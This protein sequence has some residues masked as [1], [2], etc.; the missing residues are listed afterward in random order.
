MTEHEEYRP[1]G[2]WEWLVLG[3][4]SGLIAGALKG[5]LE[6]I[7]ILWRTSADDLTV[8]PYGVLLYG[9]VAAVAG[10]G[11]GMAGGIL[12]LP[13]RKNRDDRHKIY[14]I[15][16]TAN[17][18]IMVFV[19]ARFRILRDLFHERIKTTE[20]MGIL[21][22]AGLLLACLLL[23]LVFTSLLKLMM[24]RVRLAGVM[25]RPWCS[26]ILYAILL[27][28]TGV[29]GYVPHLIG[30]TE[31][32]PIPSMF[33]QGDDPRPNVLLIMIDTQRAD[34]LSCY[35][36]PKSISPNIDRL[37]SEGILYTNAIAQAS[38]TK[39]SIATVLSSMY[40]SSHQA[41]H[42]KSI[43]PDEVVTLAE[44]L[45]ENGYYTIGLSNNKNISPTFHFEQGFEHYVFLEPDYFFGASEVSSQLAFYH[46]LRI[47]K[48]RFF[49]SGIYVQHFYQDAE[50]VTDKAISW[51][52]D[53]RGVRSFLFVHYMDPHG[54]Y[55]Y[56]PYDGRGYSRIHMANPPPK[57]AD[58]FREVY[59][60]EV[61][62]CDA[63]I[64]RLL[65]WMRENGLYDQTLI[66][67]TGDHGEEF[68]EHG[69][70]WHGKTLYEEQIHIPLIVKLPGT[71]LKGT[72][73]DRPVRHIDVAPTILDWLEL[74][75][76]DAWQG[77]PLLAGNDPEIDH[78][79]FSEE[80]FEGNVVR[81]I[82][83]KDRKLILANEGNPRGLKPME[84]YHL[85]SD[86]EESNNLVGV[87]GT[88]SVVSE[89]KA[90]MEGIE[91]YAVKNSVQ[92]ETKELDA[93]TQ[94]QLKALGYIQ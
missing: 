58:L 41:I 70:W 69:G 75:S 88:E 57:A 71:E 62:F 14:S 34:H 43:L 93:A 33:L 35:G 60:G 8:I 27:F 74:E 11:Y 13:F 73:I 86:P 90:Y 45:Q 83:S 17:F 6:G 63:H 5:I 28:V 20:P 1:I 91:N 10:I 76:P 77:S 79:V 94:E 19:I 82:R 78:A 50:V 32:K 53:H 25:I 59:E 15:L 23:F 68:F 55:F 12:T 80:D 65:E 39:P 18:M 42:K 29:V 87:A 46:L 51:M 7:T 64:G 21:F 67:L 47:I 61:A 56:H 3:I 92:A 37:S 54:P 9:V 22:H 4:T 72:E 48:V 49:S 26:I 24:R 40:P 52:T 85:E 84:L 31:S 89:L 30:T 81:S 38:W 16:F 2:L 44:V 66:L 36:Y